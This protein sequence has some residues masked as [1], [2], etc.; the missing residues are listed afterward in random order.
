MFDKTKTSLPDMAEVSQE[1]KVVTGNVIIN[2]I[3]DRDPY[4]LRLAVAKDS[5]LG[6]AFHFFRVFLLFFWGVALRNRPRIRQFGGL[7]SNKRHL[8]F[9]LIHAP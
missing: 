1:W 3:S 5:P 9:M 4:A 7:K 2:Y 6:D 8:T